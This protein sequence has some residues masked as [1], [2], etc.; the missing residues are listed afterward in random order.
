MFQLDNSAHSGVGGD[1]LSR[2]QS[3]SHQR[4]S[5]QPIGAKI[6]PVASDELC[7]GILLGQF[8]PRDRLGRGDQVVALFELPPFSVRHWFCGLLGEFSVSRCG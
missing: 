2:K 7:Q 5:T 3:V 6:R 1:R 4:A 8:R